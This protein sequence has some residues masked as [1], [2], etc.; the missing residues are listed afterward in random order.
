MK[1]KRYMKPDVEIVRLHTSGA[2]M[3]IGDLFG[4]MSESDED[5]KDGW[6]GANGF[7]FDEGE[8]EEN[9]WAKPNNLWE[10]ENY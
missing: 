10:E 2:V 4:G 9:L 8:E 5:S 7:Q 1:N 3:L 6:V